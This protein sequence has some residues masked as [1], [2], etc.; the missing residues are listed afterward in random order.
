MNDMK[1]DPLALDTLLESFMKSVGD[2]WSGA[3]N[4]WSGLPDNARTGTKSATGMGQDAKAAMAAAMKNWQA[5][6]TAMA[7]W[8]STS[9]LLKSAGTMPEIMAQLVQKSM[10]SFFQLQTRMLDRTGRLGEKAETFRL[11]N[12]D[13]NMFRVWA[14]IYEKE[15][16]KFFHIPQLGLTR[17]YQERI[18]HLIDYYNIFQT[19]FAEFLRLLG[20][21]FIQSFRVMQEK[22][23]EFTETGS[24][25]SDSQV[26]YQMWI[27]TLEGHYMKL[28][29]TPE[30]VQA[31][32]R[33][34]NAWANFSSSKNALLEDVLSVLPVANR[35]EMDSLSREVYE[36]KKRLRK[37]EKRTPE[38]K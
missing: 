21:P 7:T 30:Y 31:L 33:A 3:A 36:L 15:F 26:Y 32:G 2:F 16:R 5:I 10:D 18:S 29:Q 8:D 27:K 14:E 22:I 6:V 38:V 11:E 28:F 12:L 25:P 13:E 19:A 4:P 1:G 24:L 35:T 23:A 17:S 20:L 9:A 37:L 34:V